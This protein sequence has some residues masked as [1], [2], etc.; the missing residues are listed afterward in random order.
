MEKDTLK[1]IVEIPE[2]PLRSLDKKT[3]VVEKISQ[4]NEELAEQEIVFRQS[5][6]WNS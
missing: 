5:L 3:S 6:S 4:L 1:L 2:V